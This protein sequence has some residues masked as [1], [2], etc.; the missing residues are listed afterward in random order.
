M[1]PV[2]AVPSLKWLSDLSLARQTAGGAATGQPAGRHCGGGVAL[3]TQDGMSS[4]CLVAVSINIFLLCD[5]PLR[6]QQVRCLALKMTKIDQIGVDLEQGRDK[7]DAFTSGRWGR[8]GPPRRHSR[9]ARQPRN[10]VRDPISRPRRP[11]PASAANAL[12]ITVTRDASAAHRPSAACARKNAVS[13]S[14]PRQV[15]RISYPFT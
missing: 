10:V 5:A 9:S 2:R 14:G 12:L 11:P 3:L 7:G 8:H 13:T 4:Q 15:R 1:R 6:I